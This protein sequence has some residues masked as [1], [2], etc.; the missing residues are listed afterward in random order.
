MCILAL[1]LALTSLT[2]AILPA[3][4]KQKHADNMSKINRVEQEHDQIPRL[5]FLNLYEPVM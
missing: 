1:A 4:P 2:V 3:S 5:E